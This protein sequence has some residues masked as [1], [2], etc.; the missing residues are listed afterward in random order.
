MQVDS[1]DWMAGILAGFGCDFT[2][3][4]PPELRQSVAAL[5][6]RLGAQVEPAPAPR[7]RTSNS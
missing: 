2:V 5:A 4:E 1:L 3:V 7:G 6:R